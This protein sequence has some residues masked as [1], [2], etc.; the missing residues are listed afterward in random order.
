MKKSNLL[1]T[2][3]I[4]LLVLLGISLLIR[5]S[6]EWV[7]DPIKVEAKDALDIWIDK[8]E[9]EE[10]CPDVGLVDSNGKLSYG[11]LCFQGETFVAYAKKY[12]L[13]PQAEPAEL[14]N[15]VSDEYYQK[16]LAR[17]MVEENYENWRHWFNSSNRMGYPPR[18]E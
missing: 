7:Y 13:I 12:N 8:L 2:F 6:R 17:L 11:P 1:K 10:G 15:F 3:W 18:K 9:K 4:W 5:G 16:K 14:M